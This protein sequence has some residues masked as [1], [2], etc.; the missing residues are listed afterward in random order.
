MS[1][2]HSH[3]IRFARKV[4]DVV[5]SQLSNLLTE[6]Q[7]QAAEPIR[8]TIQQIAGGVWVGRGAD[9]FVEEVSNLMLPGV[10]KIGGHLTTTQTNINHAIETIDQADEEIANR[11][12]RLADQFANIYH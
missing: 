6:V 2:L 9:A 8:G 4:V 1:S 5:Q 7:E 11:V 3:L 12:N 10:G